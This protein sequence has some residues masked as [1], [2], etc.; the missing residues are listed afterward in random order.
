MSGKGKLKRVKHT[1]RLRLSFDTVHTPADCPFE[2][3]ELVVGND[4]Y[5]QDDEPMLYMKSGV[6]VNIWFY[7]EGKDSF[8]IDGWNRNNSC[9]VGSLEDMLRQLTRFLCLSFSDEK[10]KWNANDRNRVLRIFENWMNTHDHIW[11]FK[12]FSFG[13]T[14]NRRQDRD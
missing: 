1:M 10:L 7:E 6:P 14:K 9:D 5:G 4:P 12:I 13:L 8:H 2:K 3:I 11:N